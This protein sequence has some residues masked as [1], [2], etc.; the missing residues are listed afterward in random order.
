MKQRAKWVYVR[1]KNVRKKLDWDKREKIEEEEEEK[2]EKPGGGE[3]GIQGER[4]LRQWKKVQHTINRIKK[5]KE[6][7][8]LKLEVSLSLDNRKGRT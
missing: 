8:T 5:I 7:T 2:N 4:K 3:E 6:E 1:T